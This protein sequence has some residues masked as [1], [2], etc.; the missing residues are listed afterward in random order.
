[1]SHPQGC[2][3]GDDD[4]HVI[5]QGA[6]DFLYGQVDRDHVVALNATAAGSVVIKPW[7]QS[8]QNEPVSRT[9]TARVA[10]LLA[11]R[12]QTGGR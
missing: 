2:Q 3:C 8:T 9:G 1:M 6:Q 10:W 12:S 7:D 11:G 5:L 4:A